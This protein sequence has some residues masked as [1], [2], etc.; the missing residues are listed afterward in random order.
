MNEK[1]PTYTAEERLNILEG[2]E[3]G[4]PDCIIGYDRIFN[5]PIRLKELL[6]VCG[7]QSVYVSLRGK[8]LLNNDD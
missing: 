7:P 2:L 6:V 1:K 5:E 4:D 8:E 3:P